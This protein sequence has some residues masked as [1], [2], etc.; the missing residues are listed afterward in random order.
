MPIR[1]FTERERRRDHGKDG[2]PAFIAYR[3]RVYDVSQSFLWQNG[4]HQALH[5]AGGDLTNSLMLSEYDVQIG[6]QPSR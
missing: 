2:A 6:H 5:V 1:R 4:S 3:G